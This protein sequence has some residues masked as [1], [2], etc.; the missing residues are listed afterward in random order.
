MTTTGE[1]SRN[2]I[3]EFLDGEVWND[4]LLLFYRMGKLRRTLSHDRAHFQV[5][6]RG[7]EGR[8]EKGRR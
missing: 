4:N 1:H 8:R 6:K 5:E 7:E 2:C 3:Q